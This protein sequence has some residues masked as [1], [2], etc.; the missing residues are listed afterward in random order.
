MEAAIKGQDAVINAVGGKTPELRVADGT[1]EV[2]PVEPR[3]CPWSRGSVR[4]PGMSGARLLESPDGR[5]DCLLIVVE[6]FG[7]F[8]REIVEGFVR[9]LGINSDSLHGADLDVVDEFPRADAPEQGG[10][11]SHQ[12]R[13]RRA[14]NVNHFEGSPGTASTSN[15][16]RPS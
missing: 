5:R 1:A 11:A 8:A 16:T 2:V 9:S 4:P 15:H 7:G 14:W 3:Q 6:L 13:T 12:S 10:S